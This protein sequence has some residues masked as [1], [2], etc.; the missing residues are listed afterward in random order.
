[1]GTCWRTVTL[2]SGRAQITSRGAPPCPCISARATPARNAFSTSTATNAQSGQRAA[3][4]DSNRCDALFAAPASVSRAPAPASWKTLGAARHPVTGVHLVLGAF[5]RSIVDT[6]A[7][8]K[9]ARSSG[10]AAATSLD[11]LDTSSLDRKSASR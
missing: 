6:F 1:M 3:S 8:A 10:T 9:I 11:S 5:E 2:P 7:L 4:E